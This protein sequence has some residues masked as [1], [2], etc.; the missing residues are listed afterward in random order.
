MNDL[1]EFDIEYRL[2]PVN[3]EAHLFEIELSIRHP[4]PLGQQLSLPAWIPGSYLIRDFAR[5]VVELKAWDSRGPREVCKRD[6]QTWAVD[7]AVGVLHVRY[8]VYAWDLSVRSAHLDQTHAFFN[9][10]SVFLAVQGQTEKPCSVQLVRPMGEAYYDWRVATTLPLAGAD[11]WEFGRYQAAD[12][13]ELIDHPVEMGRF[14]D[15]RFIAG[16][17]PHD[18]VFSGR[19]STDAE[20]IA[21]DVK[22]I[23]DSH[24]GMFGELPE[25][26]RYVFLVWVLG[27]GFGGLEHRS[28]CSLMASRRDLPRRSD[29]EI[30]EDYSRFLSLCSHEYFHLWHVKRIKPAVF[31][32]YDL[33][34]ETHTRQLWA[35]EGITSYYDD[36][37]L[38]RTQLLTVRSYLELLGQ[39]LTR[40]QRTPGRLRQ[41]V[42]DASFDAWIKHY[43]PD[44][45]S[46]NATV[47][48]YNKGAVV[49]CA[50][51]LT[52]RLETQF[53]KSLDD[54]MRALWRDFGKPGIGIPEDGLETAIV[55][56]VGLDLR[57]FFALA[58]YATE[59]IPLEPLLAQFGVVL[60]QRCAL[61]QSDKG[62]QAAS[63]NRPRTDWGIRYQAGDNGGVRLSVVYT[64]G[65]AQKAG[66]SAQDEII[67]VDGLRVSASQ[68]EAHLNYYPVGQQ[69]E[70]YAFR[71]DEL[72]RFE[73]T[74]EPAA[75]DTWYCELVGDTHGW[76]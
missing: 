37:A 52:I 71:R 49:A 23:C 2:L 9:G 44:E 19:F 69:V 40:L 18:M 72:M 35:F 58:L 64:H 68:W 34:R 21:Q 30:S 20:R 75:T 12:Y 16:G 74:P 36:L 59:E 3:P 65:A 17:V 15:V 22:K 31:M 67:A 28:S 26:K 8:E 50:L 70:V 33:T 46:A 66:L 41:S 76:I 42:T 43:R 13:D 47:S 57:E 55:R 1:H 63:N 11:L 7:S 27:D 24:I 6:K 10:S 4:D 32:P 56:A 38:V 51:D 48:Y 25:F 54:V 45:N 14:T 53:T 29:P 5:C 60:R 39:S 62:G 73:V 61:S